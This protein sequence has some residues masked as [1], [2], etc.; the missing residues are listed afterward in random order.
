MKGF[1]FFLAFSLVNF[2]NG[3]IPPSPASQTRPGTYRVIKVLPH[4]AKAF[5]QGLVYEN[6]ILYE[7]TG[8]YGES[9]LRQVQPNNGQVIR[10]FK[11][12]SHLFGEGIAIVKDRIYQL[13]WEAGLC[14]VYSKEDLR[15]LRT[16]HYPRPKEG[17][18]MTH[19]GRRLV[20]S[21]GSSFL[22]FLDAKTL[23]VRRRLQV[24]DRGR[25]VPMLNEL[26]YVDGYIYANIWQQSRIVVVDEDTGRITVWYDLNRL[27][28][29]HLR[30][31]IDY[32]LNGIAHDPATGLFYI[33]GKM[34]PQMYVI[35]FQG[36]A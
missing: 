6:G 21:D 4:D 8:Q 12:P 3:D 19:N 34:W 10:S 17:W 28:P 32:V 20:V 29:R 31:H 23:K 15:L 36:G 11:L 7:G 30:G 33:T 27:V 35:E 22:Y 9:T 16:I 13:T 1:L 24:H 25:P 14:L 26:E 5:T 18:G 2:L